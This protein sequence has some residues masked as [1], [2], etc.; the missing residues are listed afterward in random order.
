M[1]LGLSAVIKKQD[2]IADFSR[3]RQIGNTNGT[4]LIA[5]PL[6]APGPGVVNAGLRLNSSSC[7]SVSYGSDFGSAASGRNTKGR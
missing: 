6:R 1:N 7:I 5:R 4:F 2:C 3:E